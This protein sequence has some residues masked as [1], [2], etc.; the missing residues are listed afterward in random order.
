MVARLQSVCCSSLR[1]AA[2]NI[3]FRWGELNHDQTNNYCWTKCFGKPV[4]ETSIN[5]TLIMRNEC[6]YVCM[7]LKIQKGT[8]GH[9][10]GHFLG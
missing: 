5:T 1:S 4:P 3:Y 10:K 8:Q 6:M 2:Y 9:V 7:H